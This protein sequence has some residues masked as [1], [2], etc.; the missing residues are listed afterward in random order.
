MLRISCWKVS[1]ADHNPKTIRV[2]LLMPRCVENVVRLRLSGSSG[3]CRKPCQRLSFEKWQAPFRSCRTSS[4][5]GV[6]CRSRWTASFG[7][8][9]SMQQCTSSGL[10]GLGTHTRGPWCW[11]IGIFDYACIFQML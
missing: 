11:A 6:G 8:L 1:G 10:R 5:V 3:I 9:I 7:S 2:N 4:I